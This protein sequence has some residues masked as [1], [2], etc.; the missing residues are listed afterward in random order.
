[1]NNTGSMER[2]LTTKSF[3]QWTAATTLVAAG[4]VALFSAATL[5]K[6]SENG[7]VSIDISAFSK[8]TRASLALDRIEDEKLINEENRILELALFSQA[9]KLQEVN[10]KFRKIHVARVQKAVTPKAEIITADEEKEISQLEQAVDPAIEAQKLANIYSRVRFKFLAAVER[11]EESNTLQ[12]ASIETAPSEIPIIDASDIELPPEEIKTSASSALIISAAKEEP[13]A[14]PEVMATIQNQSAPDRVN[15]DPESGTPKEA[16]QAVYSPGLDLIPDTAPPESVSIQ[17]APPVNT[18]NNEVKLATGPPHVEQPPKSEEIVKTAQAVV[19]PLPTADEK[20]TG[21]GAA[22]STTNVDIPKD[23]SADIASIYDMYPDEY[24]DDTDYSVKPQKKK[25]TSQTLTENEESS[26]PKNLGNGVYSDSKGTTI[27]WNEK[28]NEVPRII[29]RKPEDLQG[30]IVAAIK[31]DHGSKDF[32]KSLDKFTLIMSGRNLTHAVKEKE[33]IETL[34]APSALKENPVKCETARFGVEA[35]DPRPEKESLSICRRPLSLEGSRG[36][37]QSMWWVAYNT[38]KEQW[39]TL[40]YRRENEISET[41]RIP[42]LTSSSLTLL[43]INAKTNTHTGMGILFGELPRGL[44]IK[45]SGRSDAPV[46]LGTES[47]SVRQFIFFN[48]QPGQPL[49]SVKNTETGIAG[50]IPLLIKARAGTFI[51]VPEPKTIDLRF[52]VYDASS[53]KEK[54]L[55][56]LT[57][58]LVGQA[59]KIG[60]TNKK[61]SLLITGAVTLGNYPLYLDVLEK[62]QGYKNRYRVNTE[63]QTG[64]SAIIPLFF[65]NEKRVSSWIHQLSGGVSP[66]SGLIVGALNSA[67]LKKQIKTPAVHVGLLEKKSSLIPESYSLSSKDNLEVKPILSADDSRFIGV[68]VPEGAAIPSLMDEMGTLLWSEIVY[69]QPGVINVVGQ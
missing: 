17:Q 65:F 4:S 28:E 56:G 40:I 18:Q 60:I 26:V 27:S 39:P 32:K 25:S 8:L 30:T 10:T 19:P 6:I 49:L 44:E 15:P 38:E 7:P 21:N 37:K 31:P 61:G 57:A 59:G 3:C 34:V 13:T 54:A 58:E 12:I 35:F 33:E 48:V 46:Y 50:A 62:E 14:K 68:Q 43:S 53:K 24:S 45:L 11:T 1:M 42:I 23:Y 47:Q 67:E 64:K 36:G 51:K 20:V 2:T 22:S 41:N 5:D 63:V 9:E 29:V 16:L 55:S 66:F 52:T 69:A